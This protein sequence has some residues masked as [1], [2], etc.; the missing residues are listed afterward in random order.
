LAGRNPAH[1]GQQQIGQAGAFAGAGGDEV[2]QH[3]AG[4][5]E[6]GFAQVFGVAGA[7]AA[8]QPQRVG[9][10]Q[11]AGVGQPH[12]HLV[13][14]RCQALQ[15][16][17]GRV[18]Q[19]GVFAALDVGAQLDLAAFELAREQLTQ[20]RLMRAKLIGQAKGKVQKAAVDRTQLHGHARGGNLPHG[21]VAL[22]GGHG[23]LA[24]G[25]AGH[26]VN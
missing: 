5:R 12:A 9:H 2:F 13:L 15:C 14:Q 25:E 24:A 16:A 6:Q 7:G 18:G 21:G 22:G 1:A 8:G 23:L 17:R 10:A 11:G 20:S 26:T 19:G 3:R 4:Q